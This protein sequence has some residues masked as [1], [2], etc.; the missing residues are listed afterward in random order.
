[1]SSNNN[2]GGDNNNNIIIKPGGRFSWADDAEET[3]GPVVQPPA[4]QASTMDL[5]VNPPQQSAVVDPSTATIPRAVTYLS[6]NSQ[7]E[8]AV[9][10]TLT[11]PSEDYFNLVNQETRRFGAN[12]PGEHIIN[13]NATLGDLRHFANNMPTSLVDQPVR[14]GKPAR[15][16]IAAN[17]QQQSGAPEPSGSAVPDD[18][19]P[20]VL[21]EEAKVN[22][23]QAAAVTM[24]VAVVA[25]VALLPALGQAPILHGSSPPMFRSPAPLGPIIGMI[26]LVGYARPLNMTLTAHAPSA[27]TFVPFG[28]RR[29]IIIL[30]LSRSHSLSRSLSR[31]VEPNRNGRDAK[32]NT[33]ADHCLGGEDD[34]VEGEDR[35]VGGDHLVVSLNSRIGV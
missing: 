18:D 13:I 34:L 9:T 3:L 29:F 12:H 11:G 27:A 2:N 16:A 4:T 30:N 35:L 26:V 14:R 33:I 22:S 5:D 25:V 20:A 23:G 6:G 8:L 32:G 17:N 1:M 7:R 15:P 28:S 31:R 21:Q 24:E 19:I 10:E